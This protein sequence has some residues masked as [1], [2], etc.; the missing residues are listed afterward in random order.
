MAVFQGRR[1]LLDAFRQGERSAMAEVYSY[2]VDEVAQL[3]RRG[4]RL[5]DGKSLLGVRDS[6]R[7][8]DLLQD[9]FL[10]AFGAPARQSYDGLRPYGPYLMRIARNLLVD[11]ARLGRRFV[12]LEDP[13]GEVEVLPEEDAAP[14]EALEWRQLSAATREFCTGVD[15]PTKE[16][17]RLRFEE[18]LSQRDV[19]ERMQWTRRKV[20]TW[21]DRVREQLRRFLIHRDKRRPNPAP[22]T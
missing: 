9:V 1:E 16:F 2:Y 20:R 6:Q 3:L 18:D 4:C 12:P 7:H 17:I 13:C 19:A 15:A 11:E 21:E 10:K 22:G 14:E 5:S 8:R